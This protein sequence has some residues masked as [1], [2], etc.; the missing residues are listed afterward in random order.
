MPQ[1]KTRQKKK[2]THTK[3]TAWAVLA[4]GVA[5]CAVAL[6]GGLGVGYFTD[7]NLFSSA[8][9]P[10]VLD[11]RYEFSGS[12]REKHLSLSRSEKLKLNKSIHRNGDVIKGVEIR[13]GIF[14]SRKDIHPEDKLLLTLEF[15]TTTGQVIQS[16][17]QETSR[18]H[19][20]GKMVRYTALA[21]SEYRRYRDMGIEFSFLWI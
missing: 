16:R 9:E 11:S 6:G 14:T 19:L 18:R 10:V 7:S 1:G 12:V 8:P 13:M 3:V 5:F 21:G 15:A 17:P 2:Q 20:I 4:W